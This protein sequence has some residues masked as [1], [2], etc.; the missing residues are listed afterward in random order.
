MFSSIRMVI[1]LPLLGFQTA[2]IYWIIINNEVNNHIHKNQRS[3][4]LP[5]VNE[6]DLT[7][8]DMARNDAI[9]VVVGV[10]NLT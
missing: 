3:Q 1:G 9:V 8:S 4:P 5:I 10:V 2:T 7:V 6:N